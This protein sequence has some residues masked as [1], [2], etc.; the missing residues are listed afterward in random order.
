MAEQIETDISGNANWRLKKV[1]ELWFL[2]IGGKLKRLKMLDTAIKVDLKENIIFADEDMY[3]IIDENGEVMI[4]EI[5]NIDQDVPFVRKSRKQKEEVGLFAGNKRK[6]LTLDNRQEE[7]YDIGSD[8]YVKKKGKFR[9]FI[10]RIRQ[11]KKKKPEQKK[12]EEPLYEAIDMNDSLRDDLSVTDFD[13]EDTSFK[14]HEDDYATVSSVSGMKNVTAIFDFEKLSDEEM[15]FKKFDEL[16]IL[17]DIVSENS[18]WCYAEHLLTREKGFVPVSYVTKDDPELIAQDWWH[19]IG[20]DEA[21][22]LLSNLHRPTAGTYLVRPSDGDNIYALSMIVPATPNKTQQIVHYAIKSRLGRLYIS[23]GKQFKDIFAL[24]DHYK[25]EAYGL[26]WK[27]KIPALRQKPVIYPKSIEIHKKSIDIIKSIKVG[28]F[29]VLY[30]GILCNIFDVT[31]VTECKSEVGHFLAEANH[32][33]EFLH[34]QHFVRVIAVVLKPKP[35]MIVLLETVQD[36]L[37]NYLRKCDQTGVS[38]K[39]MTNMAAE[40]A[41]GMAFLEE[42]GIVHGNLKA[43]NVLICEHDK[44]KIL[45]PKLI[46]LMGTSVNDKHEEGDTEWQWIAPEVITDESVL[47][48][49]SDVWSFG[50]VIYETLT[51][52][53]VPYAGLEKERTL[54]DFFSGNFRLPIPEGQVQ[55]PVEFYNTIIQCWNQIPDHRPTFDWLYNYLDDFEN[56]LESEKFS[57]D[58]HVDQ[59]ASSKNVDITPGFDVTALYDYTAEADNEISFDPGDIITNIDPIDAGWWIGTTASGKRGLFPANYVIS[60]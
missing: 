39:R 59:T 9:V 11:I 17:E 47:C 41:E 24:V 2:D 51:F 5:K 49:K 54:H 16:T 10:D 6:E 40:I 34:S 14:E 21:T 27:L 36:T 32:L 3:Q 48:T 46:K 15:T 29:G 55:C 13:D 52:G 33:Y 22:I 43:E 56:A 44:L 60:R 4:T 58:A 25:R 26:R 57:K 38:F 19:N 35:F 50:V 8:L 30:E 37:Q 28:K 31:I 12:T 42:K 1:N 20:R 7:S 18:E 53:E 45:H 23:Y